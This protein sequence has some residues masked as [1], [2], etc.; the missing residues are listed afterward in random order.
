MST[1]DKVITW[2]LVLPPSRPSAYHLNQIRKSIIDVDRRRPVAVLGSTPEFR[3][4]LHEEGFGSIYVFDNNVDVYEMMSKLR[5]YSNVEQLI[6]GDWLQTIPTFTDFFPL[7]L[8]DLTMGNVAYEKRASFY[9]YI[10]DSLCPSGQF[11]DKVLTHPESHI[12]VTDL[13]RKYERLPLNLLHINGFSCE[14]F[15]CSELLEISELL[16]TANFYNILGKEL[17]HGR[18]KC[19]LEQ[20]T[21][22]T[23]IDCI[24]YYGKR[25][26]ILRPAYC[27]KLRTMSISEDEV[28]SPYYGRLKLFFHCK[29]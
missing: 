8:S 14:F 10:T 20:C 15:F 28:Q 11:I 12:T 27:P 24:W 17:K 3:D 9:E 26:D 2:D 21:K 4:M 22:I 16:D 13:A 5:V 7:I 19:F 6:E 29:E 25:W 1:W 18:L 23:P